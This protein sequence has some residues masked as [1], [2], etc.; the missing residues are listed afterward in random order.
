[1]IGSILR[2]QSV[3]L[4]CRSFSAAFENGT[5]IQTP[6]LPVYA[7]ICDSILS[8]FNLQVIRYGAGP[9]AGGGAD[10]GALTQ[11][12]P[13]W[14]DIVVRVAARLAALDPTCFIARQLPGL[15]QHSSLNA[16]AEVGVPVV[17]RSP[18]PRFVVSERSSF[19][20]PLRCR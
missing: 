5:R 2:H 12:P 4:T 3:K 1:M 18:R 17:G 16:V 15:V 19:V 13:L 11:L 20:R 7:L 10:P 9:P 8:V 6:D 14:P